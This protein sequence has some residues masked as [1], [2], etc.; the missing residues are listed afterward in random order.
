[1]EEEFIKY[2]ELIRYLIWYNTERVQSGLGNVSLLEWVC[3]KFNENSHQS[4]ILWTYIHTLDN[5]LLIS[6][7]FKNHD[8]EV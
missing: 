1:M 2:R 4:Q 6:K 3:Y 8:E 7:I 5:L